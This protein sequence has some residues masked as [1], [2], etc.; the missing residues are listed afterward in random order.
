MD[1]TDLEAHEECQILYNAL[2]ERLGLEK[3]ADS[4]LNSLIKKLIKIKQ[5]NPIDG[6]F[7]H[8]FDSNKKI[9]INYREDQS[10]YENCGQWD[11]YTLR[12]INLVRILFSSNKNNFAKIIALTFFTK[13]GSIDENSFLPNKVSIPQKIKNA[14][15]DISSVQFA[16]DTLKLSDDEAQILQVAYR[17]K[18][19]KE[20]Y[21]VCNDLANL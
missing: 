6:K 19:V 10:I 13:P 5:L 9:P 3:H 12:D 20:L 17:I 2:V 21:F 4:V 7:K 1:I 14:V 8:P 16:I 15:K 18:S 11:T